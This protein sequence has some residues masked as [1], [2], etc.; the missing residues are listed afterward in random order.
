MIVSHCCAATYFPEA[1]VLVPLSSV[2]DKSNTPCSKQVVVK[3]GRGEKGEV[4]SENRSQKKS[5]PFEVPKKNKKRKKYLIKPL[6]EL[7][8]YLF[9]V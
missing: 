1:N 6:R 7:Q 9:C 4:K 3:I 8:L 5:T 2:A